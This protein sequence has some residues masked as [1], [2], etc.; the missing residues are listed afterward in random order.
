MNLDQD[1]YLPISNN[2]QL[3]PDVRAVLERIVREI[4]RGA[5]Q[6]SVLAIFVRGSIASGFSLGGGRSDLDLIV[7]TKSPLADIQRKAIR[8]TTSDIANR[9][10]GVSGSDILYFSAQDTLCQ[11]GQSSL[12]LNTVLRNYSILIYGS[13]DRI[14]LVFA[15]KKPWYSLSLDIR[16]DE[17]S[18]LRAFR[19]GSEQGDIHLQLFSIK[20]ICKRALR[21]SAELACDK[22]R[23]HSRDLVPCYQFSVEAFPTYEKVFL[24][25]LQFACACAENK[26]LELPKDELLAQGYDAARNIVEVVEELCLI[27]TFGAQKVNTGEGL[28]IVSADVFC[29]RGIKEDISETFEQIIA[30]AKWYVRPGTG[31]LDS[32]VFARSEHPRIVVEAAHSIEETDMSRDGRPSIARFLSRIERPVVF[33]GAFQNANVE[34]SSTTSTIL[35]DLLRSRISVHCRVSPTNVFTFCRSTHPWIS[36]KTFTPPSRLTEIGTAEAVARLQVDHGLPA[37]Y[38]SDDEHIYIQTELHRRQ[39]LFKDMEQQPVRIAQRERMWVSGH[40][41]VSSLHYDASWSGLVQRAGAKRIL[42]FEPGCLRRMGA[43][44]MGHPLGR[45]VRVDVGRKGTAVFQKFW[46]E[47]DRKGVEVWLYPGD[48]VVF[49]AFW[50]HYTES[51]AEKGGLSISHTVRFV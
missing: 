45:R 19:N 24:L 51:W 5:M 40:G 20:W 37:L 35:T 28:D 32:V 34:Q 18:F 11:E 17:R 29:T 23:K 13:T 33:R 3:E 12:H 38:Y 15:R 43:Y 36:S 2:L 25:G 41:T 42:F 6:Q 26:Y 31:D 14:G 27:R 30:R 50:A 10:L 22:T 9:L 47:C 46:D 4:V 7:V 39:E 48:L 16:S 8:K 1:G 49:P 44:P 21:A